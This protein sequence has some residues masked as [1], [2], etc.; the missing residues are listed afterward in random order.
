[1]RLLLDTHVLLTLIERSIHSLP[2]SIELCSR[3]RA[4]SII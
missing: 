3:T 4:M 2:A 1:M